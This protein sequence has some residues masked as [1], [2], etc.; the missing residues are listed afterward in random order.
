M[1]RSYSLP[2]SEAPSPH[3]TDDPTAGQGI[4]PPQ[5]HFHRSHHQQQKPNY[6]HLS[7]KDKQAVSASHRVNEA[8]REMH[9]SIQAEL[10]RGQYAKQ[11]LEDSSAAFRQL[12]DSYGSLDGILSS[13]RDLVGTLMKSHKSDTWYLTT[14]L[15]MLATT[16]AWLVFRRWLYGPL[17]WFLWLPLRLLFGVGSKAGGA[18]MSGS[19]GQDPGRVEVGGVGNKVPVE[20]MPDSSLPT[21]Q[22]GQDDDAVIE[23][24]DSDPDWMMEKVGRIVDAAEEAD[25]LGAIPAE[26]MGTGID[27]KA[28]QVVVEDVTDERPRD[29]L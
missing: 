29:E 1:I 4:P 20:G 2:V 14:A 13:S 27:T 16:A 28:E 11:T 18:V 10:E 9:A 23:S 6:S 5:P 24:P 26:D 17:W 7:E 3:P 15:Y 19:G 21:A 12:D 22:V 8:M 25:E